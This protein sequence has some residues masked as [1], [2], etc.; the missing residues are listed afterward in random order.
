MPVRMKNV[1]AGGLV[2]VLLMAAAPIGAHASEAE[3]WQAFMSPGAAH[4]YMAQFVGRWNIE[5]RFWHAPGQPPEI[6]R[7]RADYQMKGG[8]HVRG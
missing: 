8:S 1:L 3:A 4:T 2:V 5:T 6:T 7:G